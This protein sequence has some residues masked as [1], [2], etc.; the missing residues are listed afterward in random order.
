[1]SGAYLRGFYT[2]MREG[3]A[4][5]GDSNTVFYRRLRLTKL[6]EKR[7][8]VVRTGRSR[9]SVYEN[10]NEERDIRKLPEG[11]KTRSV[12]ADC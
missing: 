8:G 3:R 10:L 11:I 5:V 1:M 4:S 9:N 6:L 2:A 7:A 12:A